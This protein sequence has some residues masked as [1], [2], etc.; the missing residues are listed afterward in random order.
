MAIG[1]FQ[2]ASSLSIPVG[3][4]V[5]RTSGHTVT[6]RGIAD[7]IYDPAV[8]SAEVGKYPRACFVSQNGRGFRIV[9]ALVSPDAFGAR[10][11][12]D[13]TAPAQAAYDYK[14]A[15][16]LGGNLSFGPG[17]YLVALRI[18][19]RGIDISGAGRTGT[20]LNPPSVGG[21]IFRIATRE[22][23]WSALTIR[24][25]S[26]K[27]SSDLKGIGVQWGDPASPDPLDHLSS[28][29]SFERCE[30][31]DLDKCVERPFGNIG[32]TFT[33]CNFSR[34][35]YHIYSVA[36]P[37]KMHAGCF[38]VRGGHMQGSEKAVCYV[39]G[40][41]M[42]GSGQIV[43]DRV[44]MEANTGH[45]FYIKDFRGPEAVPG[46]LVRSCWNEVNAE[47]AL[48]ALR[49]TAVE[50]DGVSTPPVYAHLESVTHM[51]FEDTPVGA[52]RAVNS[53]GLIVDSAVDHYVAQIDVNSAFPVVRGRSFT[54]PVPSKVESIGPLPAATL[55]S[56]SG[57]CVIPAM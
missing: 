21:A 54:N 30:F 41:N 47:Q 57:G 52:L 35:N 15:K 48:P 29:V 16:F 39:N 36:R 31:V 25:L 1:L 44:I 26:F 42:T 51:R 22:G 5:V 40:K 20:V 12:A 32:V 9:G 56:H 55:L 10:G 45:V 28:A 6:G 34:A 8:D 17:Q 13:D 19:V 33:D 3:T 23:S 50:V 11:P 4:N 14:V 53:G 18:Y 2:E 49:K 24:D 7:Y 46:I 38:E 43:F 27:G 37:D